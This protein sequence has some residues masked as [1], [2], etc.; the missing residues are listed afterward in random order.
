MRDWATGY[1]INKDRLNG[2]NR[3]FAEQWLILEGLHVKQSGQNLLDVSAGKAIVEGYLVESAG[4]EGLAAPDG[5]NYVYLKVTEIVDAGG[6]FTGV[7]S[8]IINS[9]V[10]LSDAPL[11]Y[12]R[13]L[14]QIYFAAGNILLARHAW[15]TLTNKTHDRYVEDSREILMKPR[16]DDFSHS[17]RNGVWIPTTSGSGVVDFQD[18]FVE[19]FVLGAGAAQIEKQILNWALDSTLVSSFEL[20]LNLM[21]WTDSPALP[22]G[23]AEFGLGDFSNNLV[24]FRLNI[25]PG[26]PQTIGVD[27]CRY[28]A[29]AISLNKSIENYEGAPDSVQPLRLRIRFSRIGFAEERIDWFYFDMRGWSEIV[30]FPW[31]PV[32][33]FSQQRIC[34]RVEATESFERIRVRVFGGRILFD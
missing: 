33:L 17:F 16:L 24:G 1:R 29:G 8:E 21:A 19:L 11:L 4:A 25:T 9:S 14:A 6:G 22:F 27:A 5:W 28:E 15:Q 10:P 2:A 34:V 26:T 23:F 30:S 3:L 13:L 7:S 32:G 31:P 12:Y 18:S 20:A